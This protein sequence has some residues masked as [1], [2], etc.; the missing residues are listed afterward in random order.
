MTANQQQRM[1]LELRLAGM[2]FDAIADRLLLD[3]WQAAKVLYEQ[4]LA[5][6]TPSDGE[7]VELEVARLER[8]HSAMWA[9]AV[10][11][12]MAATDVVMRI[13]E[14]RHELRATARLVRGVEQ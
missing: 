7:A 10:G 1:V 2:S 8:L 9:K 4:A 5:D 12:D 14:R 13:A 6:S 3:D 11:G